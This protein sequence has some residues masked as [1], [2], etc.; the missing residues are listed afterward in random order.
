MV[1][2][3]RSLNGLL[4]NIGGTLSNKRKLLV[5]A[6][7][8]TIL[9]A[10]PIWGHLL[11]YKKYNKVLERLQ[12]RMA[13]RICSAYKT[14]STVALQVLADDLPIDLKMA[15]AIEQRER[16]DDEEGIVERH[17]RTLNLWQER[18]QSEVEWT[19][20][21]IP[22]LRSYVNRK[23]GVLYY[24]LTQGLTGHGCFKAY[25]Y[26]FKRARDDA[27]V[28]CGGCDTAEHTIFECDRW[29]RARTRVCMRVGEK[30]SPD[31]MAGKM[32]E[33][34]EGWNVI[35]GFIGGIMKTKEEEERRHVE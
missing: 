29:A 19:Q 31:N 14:T 17:V 12:R 15:Q 20:R 7:Y 35:S 3:T 34:E 33:F 22:D 24:F 4:P 13:L 25:L 2:L 21:L 11:R 28:Q 10:A 8:S 18:W 16:G 1:A 27:C 6:M 32:L 26:H 5:A 9:Y 30:L 23:W